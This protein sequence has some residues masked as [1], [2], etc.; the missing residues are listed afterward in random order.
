MSDLILVGNDSGGTIASFRLCGGPG[1]QRTLDRL[2][3]TEVG[4]GCGTFAVDGDV[5]YVAVRDPE[6]A[7]VTLRLDRSNGALAEVSRR[8]TQDGLVYLA[9]ADGA[10]VGAS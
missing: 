6:P 7:V 8:A 1:G 4:V 9:V 3:A 5:V 2:A 10:L